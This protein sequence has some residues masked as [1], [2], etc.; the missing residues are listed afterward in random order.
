M[1][2]RTPV[3]IQSLNNILV[4]LQA[5]T[6]VHLVVFG[7]EF[8]SCTSAGLTLN[9]PAVTALT[10]SLNAF[11]SH[12]VTLTEIHVVLRKGKETSPLSERGHTHL[13]KASL[14]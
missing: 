8:F 12:S 2:L 10:W 6:S 4:S 7:V 5:N 11:F 14:A 9:T 3:V 1:N 13:I